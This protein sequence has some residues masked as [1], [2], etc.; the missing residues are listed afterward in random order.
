MPEM[1]FHT[2]AGYR[3]Q[4]GGVTESMEDYLEMICRYCREQGYIRINV[5]SQ[6]LHVKPS[7][8]SKMAAHLRDAGLVEFEKYGIVRPSEAGWRLGGYLLH[9]HDVLTSFFTLLN[10]N[11][12]QLEQV[13]RVEHFMEPETIRNLELLNHF[14]KN[15]EIYQMYLEKMGRQAKE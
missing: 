4:R 3:A 12:D 1:E 5:L 11:T 13:E 2:L 6:R 9:R 10:R 7:S 15:N 8:A 14:L